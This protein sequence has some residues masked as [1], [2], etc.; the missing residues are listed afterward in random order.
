[1]SI[2]QAYISVQNMHAPR[3]KDKRVVRP[4]E[5]ELQTAVGAGHKIKVLCKTNKLS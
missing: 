4:L 5:P 3:V 2:L 1:M